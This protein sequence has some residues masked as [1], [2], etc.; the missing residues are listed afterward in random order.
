MMKNNILK[1]SRFP[2]LAT[3]LLA[4][5]LP[6]SCSKDALVEEV[7]TNVGT[8][9]LNT[10]AGFND[11]VRAAYAALRS[12]YGTERG[13][14][15]TIFGTDTYTNG[16]DGSWKFMNQYTAQFD[17]RT[18]IVQ[19]VWDEFYRGINVCNSVIERAPAVT[20]LDAVTLKQRVGEVKFLRAQY[21]FILTQL[22][23]GVDLRLS[24]TKEPTKVSTRA[25]VQNMYAAIVK[26]LEEAIPDLENKARSTDYGRVTRAAAEHLLSLVYLT[27]ATSDAKATDDYTKAETLAKNVIN[28]YGIKLL[29]DFAQVHQEGNEM[30]EEV[31]FATQYTRDPLTNSTGNNAHVFFLMEYDVQPGMRRDVANGRPFKRYKP[32]TYCLETVFAPANRSK[33]SRYSKTFVDVYRTNRPGTFSTT[34]DNSK[35]SVTFA[36]GDTAIYLPGVEWTTAQRAAKPYQ[37]LTPSLYTE[38]LYPSLRKHIDGGRVDLFQFEGGRDYIN[39]RLAETYLNL[40]EAQFRQGKTQDAVNSLN[41]VRRRAAWP[42]KEK[43]MEI[44]PADLTMEFIMEERERELLGEQKRWFDLKRWGVL[45]S[46]V[47]QYNPQAAANIKAHHVLRPIPQVQIDRVEGGVSAFAQN[48]GY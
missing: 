47:Q 2:S 43:D 42:G 36:A 3:L 14:N 39:Y 26:D 23:G 11:G 10:A 9:Y 35:P 28:N 48:P 38:K 21:Y 8:D 19:E 25:S 20:G 37:V 7:I 44:A 40:A 34:F 17:P 16:S 46:R 13:N 41:V 5:L 15:L 30:N 1:S 6:A 29:S 4:V 32:T 27:K 33:D 12:W 18:A 24:E 45:L 31:I 22:F